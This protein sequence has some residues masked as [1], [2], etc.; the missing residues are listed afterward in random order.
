MTVL[1]KW[2]E[3]KEAAERELQVNKAIIESDDVS[4]SW[5]KR[6]G[7][8]ASAAVSWCVYAIGL[9]TLVWGVIAYVSPMLIMVLMSGVSLPEESTALS[10]VVVLG[11]SLALLTVVLVFLVVQFMKWSRRFWSQHIVAAL[12]S[13]FGVK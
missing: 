2:R 7:F 10:I 1:S 4:V 12:A 6:F 5:P 8:K 9:F 3:K 11:P 13:L